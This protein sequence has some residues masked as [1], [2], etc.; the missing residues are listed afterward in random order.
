MAAA[1]RNCKRFRWR[2]IPRLIKRVMR[3]RPSWLLERWIFHCCPHRACF[4]RAIVWLCRQQKPVLERQHGFL[5]WQGG[6]TA[7]D[8]ENTCFIL[9][10]LIDMPE[11]F[12]PT[13][14]GSRKS[15]LVSNVE[16]LVQSQRRQPDDPEDGSWV[17][18]HTARTGLA[19]AVFYQQ[20]KE[21]TRRS[22]YS[23]DPLKI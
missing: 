5:S 6:Y 20:A 12:Q 16:W 9:E 18:G 11:T 13:S 3:C 4:E 10:T 2:V 19:L 8:Y 21:E 14:T 1:I 7:A 15:L 23:L 17:L 22:E